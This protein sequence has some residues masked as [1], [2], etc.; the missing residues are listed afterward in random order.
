MF[1]PKQKTAKPD[2]GKRSRLGNNSSNIVDLQ[3]IDVPMPTVVAAISAHT[4]ISSDIQITGA[5]VQSSRI[6]ARNRNTI[7]RVVLSTRYFI[8]RCNNVMPLAVVKVHRVG[9]CTD[10]V[11]L[12]VSVIRA[13]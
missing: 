2:Q 13:C 1:A 8:K 4:G 11:P 10:T 5:L 9:N 12:I 3:I 6:G 7:D